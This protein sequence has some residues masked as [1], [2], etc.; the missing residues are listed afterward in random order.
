MLAEG[1][2]NANLGVGIGVVLLALGGGIQALVEGMTAVVLP[3]L[4]IGLALF[5]WGCFNY[6]KGKGHSQWLGLLG[7]TF[8]GLI[9]MVCFP[10]KHKNAASAEKGIGNHRASPESHF[11]PKQ[12]NAPSIEPRVG[13]PPSQGHAA[14]EKN[15][16]LQLLGLKVGATEEEVLR[17]Y[18]DLVEVWNPDRFPHD[19][20]LQEKAR[21]RLREINEASDKLL[22]YLASSQRER[23]EAR[24]E[25][26]TTPGSGNSISHWTP[27][28]QPLGP[29][30]R[31]EPA[32]ISSIK[33][34]GK[35]PFRAAV[36]TGTAVLV[37]LL[38]LVA[39]AM[40]GWYMHNSIPSPSSH[41]SQDAPT[42]ATSKF[43]TANSFFADA[44]A[45]H[46]QGELDKAIED[47]TSAISSD[48]KSART[49][50][51]R[52]DAYH[53]KGLYGAAIG[54]FDRAIEI[55]K[56]PIYLKKR[57]LAYYERGVEL[58][59]KSE[60]AL[61]ADF[62][63]KAKSDLDRTLSARSDDAEIYYYRGVA[64]CLVGTA[65]YGLS[66]IKKAARLGYK[67]ARKY[68]AERGYKW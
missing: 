18:G 9:I 39:V 52:G 64:T 36:S 33:P 62:L 42:P 63:L 19:L 11:H 38:V 54:D 37:S 23:A 66:D 20:R 27:T 30:H 28:G 49:Y 32:S 2:R 59:E 41:S 6:M 48:P 13:S 25:E 16:Y 65:E 60:G 61:G 10:D 8:I 14:N 26:S 35:S 55:S 57:G 31:P 24:K 45:H 67:P 51:G 56:E 5:M 4:L 46:Q 15:H 47:Y 58:Y 53:S 34:K 68:L 17:A 43:N 12:E 44:I 29:A 22:T 40:I 3:F 7:L 50:A 1:K 21:E